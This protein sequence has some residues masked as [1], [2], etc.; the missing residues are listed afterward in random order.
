[1][2][3]IEIVMII[4]SHDWRYSGDGWRWRSKDDPERTGTWGDLVKNPYDRKICITCGFEGAPDA[5]VPPCN[6]VW[7][8]RTGIPSHSGKPWAG[9]FYRR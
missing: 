5:E 3:D 4:P 7:T 2:S 9:I 8:Q 1:M 6:E